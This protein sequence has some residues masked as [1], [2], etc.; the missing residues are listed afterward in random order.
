QKRQDAL[1]QAMA[2]IE[3]EVT[4][5]ERWIHL[6]ESSATLKQLRHRAQSERD[7]LLEQ[8]RAQ[9]EAGK[10]PEDVLQRF[11][12]RLV[13]RLL[14]GPSIRMRQAA[15]QSDEELLAAAR[16]FFQDEDS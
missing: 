15:E 3:A 14:H 6:H 12:H 9:I 5:F 4:A 1:R 10:D 13:N 16:F 8:A 2:L 7:K 11:G